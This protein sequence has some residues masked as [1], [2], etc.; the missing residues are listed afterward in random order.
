[1]DEVT[2]KCGRCKATKPLSSFGTNRARVDGRQNYCNDCRVGVNA[3]YYQSSKVRMNPVRRGRR[4]EA[5]T[6]AR[7]NLCRYL[8]SHPC[9]DCGETDIVVLQ[10]D[11]QG[12]KEFNVGTMVSDGARWDRI[13]AEIAKCEVVCANDHARRTARSF[14]W[15]K[16]SLAGSEAEHRTLSPRVEISKPSRRAGAA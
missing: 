15:F 13:L 2:K 5:V 1:M 12:G 14:G 11:H 4:R 9:V 8:L 3:D 6:Q 10:F 7:D 16:A